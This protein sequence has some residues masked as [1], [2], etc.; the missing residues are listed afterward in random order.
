MNEEKRNCQLMVFPNGPV[1]NLDCA[2]CYYLKKRTLYPPG[3]DFRMPEALL[4]RF[5]RDYIAM[6]AGPEVFFIWQGGEPTLRGLDF[7]KRA[8]ALQKEYLPE[9]WICHNSIQ[10]NGTL[11][12]DAWCTFFRE[13]NYL[14]GLSLDGPKSCHDI[15]RKGPS[16]Q[17]SHRKA[18]RALGLL[19]KHQVSFNVICTVNHANAAHPDEVYQYFRQKGVQYLQFIP[20][21]NLEGNAASAESVSGEEYGRFLIR[22]FDLWWR[23]DIGKIFI[24][25]FEECLSVWMTG[26]S[27][28]CV[29]AETCGNAPVME[30]NGDVYSCDHFVTEECRLGN[31]VEKTLPEMLF[32]RQQRCF[33]AQKRELAE[34]CR[35]CG[36]LRLCHG[37]C[38]RSR[39]SWEDDGKKDYLC[40]G[41]RMF[42]RHI[43]PYMEK[44]CAALRQ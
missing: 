16:G 30:H 39:V 20:I 22:V 18:E 26:H 23:Q 13:E 2:Y 11:L 1:C 27:S 42:Y 24:Q 3:E 36:F 21:V 17:G 44:L 41:N 38:L 4:E 43:A 32:G 19:K 5:V 25:T 34:S 6:Q 14:V 15:Y 28:V 40:E 9:G 10:T 37:G 33:G 35:S 8:A 29:Y 31:L 12:D 7:F